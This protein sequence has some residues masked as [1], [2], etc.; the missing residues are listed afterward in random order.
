MRTGK[1]GCV[2][3][4]HGLV[5][6]FQHA[7]CVWTHPTQ[8]YAND[9]NIVG[10]ALTRGRRGEER[11]GLAPIS[12]QVW[13]RATLTRSASEEGTTACAGFAQT[14]CHRQSRRAGRVNRCACLA[15]ASGWCG[16]GE[17]CGLVSSL[18]RGCKHPPYG[19]E[20]PFFRI[21]PSFSPVNFARKISLTPQACVSRR[22]RDM[23]CVSWSDG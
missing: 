8:L 2:E 7:W 10:V 1:V 15:C 6:T 20:S 22:F 16:A 13:R 9:G 5:S 19:L 18:A 17:K 11:K 4:H 14:E 3:T 21:L 12:H 23:R